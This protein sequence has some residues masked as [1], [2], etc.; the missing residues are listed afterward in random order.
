VSDARPASDAD[1]LLDFVRDRDVPCPLCRYNLRA[2]T[3]PVCPECRHPLALAVGIPRL[4]FEWLI[5]AV[6]PCT[7][8]GLAALLLIIP[9]IAVPATGGG[10]APP[11]I[12]LLDAF[13]WMSGAA[14]VTLILRRYAF[15]RLS[16]VAQRLIALTIWGIHLTAF[17]LLVLLIIAPN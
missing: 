5:A 13:G 9:I 6:T 10:S 16:L 1:L 17:A 3:T 4:R 14:G 15:L 12:Y 11:G 7:F 8:S 2:L